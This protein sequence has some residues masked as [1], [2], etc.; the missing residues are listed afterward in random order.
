MSNLVPV[1]CIAIC[2]DQT[3]FTEHLYK[4]IK[5]SFAKYDYDLAG[6]QIY[7]NGLNIKFIFEKIILT[8]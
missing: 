6:I 1:S 7:Q 5:E 4:L 8:S 3:E 2:D